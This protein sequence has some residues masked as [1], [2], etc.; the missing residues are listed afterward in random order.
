MSNNAVDAYESGEMPR[1]KWTKGEIL[2]RCGEKQDMIKKLTVEEM[3]NALLYMSSWH[4]TSCKY[5]RTEFY[6]FDDD[7]L[8]EM[9]EEKIAE[10][11]GKRA[12]KEK[13]EEKRTVK[14]EVTYSIWVGNY[15]RYKKKKTVTEIVTFQT[16]DKMIETSNGAK[17]MSSMEAIRYVE[18]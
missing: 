11:I 13:K 3:R 15:A 7:A 8:A 10:I 9:T 17:R 4:H 14:A 18:D 5:N 12:P 6:S 2:E 16:G 1:S